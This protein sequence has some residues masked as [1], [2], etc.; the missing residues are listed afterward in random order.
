[1][2][3]IIIRLTL[4]FIILSLVASFI[5]W[6]II[7]YRHKHPPLQQETHTLQAGDILSVSLKNNH[8]PEAEAIAIINALAKVFD[9]RKCRP[10]DNYEII[11]QKKDNRLVKFIYH[12]SPVV[13][14]QVLKDPLGNYVATKE[15]IPLDKKITTF[16][17]SIKNNLYE[18]LTS[19]G[20][21]PELVMS[22]ADIFSYEIDFLTDPRQGDTFTVVYEKYYHNNQFI[23]NGQILA[24]QYNNGG[25]GRHLAFFFEDPTGHKDYYS[26]DG[27]SLRKAFLRSPLNYRRISSYFTLRRWH[28]VLKIY[29]PH[30]GIDYAAQAG[31]PVST[32]GDGTVLFAGW[33]GGYGRFI[34]ISHPN[35]YTTTYGHL[36]GYAKGIRKGARVTQGQVIG[37]V[38]SSGLSTGPHLDFR[39]MRG[40]QFI[41]F[42]SL[43]LPQATS[44]PAKYRNSFDQVK[45]E[46]SQ[47]LGQ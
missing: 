26:T 9:L 20:E 25:N 32:I 17:G 30:L 23:K 10:G 8:L 4:L 36:N 21:S 28:P 13:S 41:N 27:K 18:A 45:K 15:T 33:E 22:F 44:I 40:K 12:P 11:I 1:M 46:R 43:S 34:K 6:R 42:M 3:K 24:A 19:S 2:R 14:Y 31:T 47:Q 16:T 5:C 38:G 35:G 7:D 39:I 29:R 37:Y